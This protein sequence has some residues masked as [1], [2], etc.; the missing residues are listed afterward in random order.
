MVNGH[1]STISGKISRKCSQNYL[2]FFIPR[3][4]I[5]KRVHTCTQYASSFK[6][7]STPVWKIERFVTRRIEEA[8]C[9]IDPFLIFCQTITVT[10]ELMEYGMCVHDK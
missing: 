5:I 1:H 9:Y 7:S 8:N 4:H 6:S 10:A 3:H 2:V